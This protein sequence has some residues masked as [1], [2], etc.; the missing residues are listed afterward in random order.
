METAG[1]VGFAEP[2]PFDAAGLLV[3]CD[4]GMMPFWARIDTE[5]ATATL[6]YTLH[7][8]ANF[9][10]RSAEGMAAVANT[11]RLVDGGLL[12]WDVVAWASDGTPLCFARQQ[13]IVLDDWPRQTD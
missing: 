4:A 6:D 12:D 5:V 7:F 11:T 8:R 1:W 10:I 3:L 13:A 2:R 9:P